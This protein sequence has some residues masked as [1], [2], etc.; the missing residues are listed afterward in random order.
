M[1]TATIMSSL[2]ALGGCSFSDWPSKNRSEHVTA[3]RYVIVHD[4]RNERDTMLLDTATGKSWHRVY[5]S[6]VEGDP[7]GWEI[8]PRSGEADEMTAFW[9]TNKAKTVDNT[10]TTTTP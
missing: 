5:Y 4:T 2:L 9:Q 6:D 1:R 8:V 7:P 10:T 3:S